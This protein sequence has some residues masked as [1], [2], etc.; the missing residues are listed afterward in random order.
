[1]ENKDITAIRIEITNHGD[2]YNLIQIHNRHGFTEDPFSCL[3]FGSYFFNYRDI[4]R[5][6]AAFSRGAYMGITKPS[7]LEDLTETDATGQCLYNLITMFQLSNKDE[8]VIELAE[9]SYYYL[10]Y[11]INKMGESAWDS[12]NS[13]ATLF[14][15]HRSWGLGHTIILKNTNTRRSCDILIIHDYI[16]STLKHNSP[17]SKNESIAKQLFLEYMSEY[18]PKNDYTIDDLIFDGD[19]VHKKIFETLE[20]KFKL[21]TL[22]NL[23]EKL[24]SLNPSS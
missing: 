16:K 14:H 17:H 1:M 8:I 2:Y 24:S 21:N 4:D 7:T 11:C 10:S 22:N 20:S 5:S 23:K 3:L 6:R 9:I 13:R 19:M 12:L 15:S 18:N